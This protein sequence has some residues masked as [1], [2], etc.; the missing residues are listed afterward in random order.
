VRVWSGK[1]RLAY[2][3]VIGDGNRILTKWSEVAAFKGDLRVEGAGGK[4]LA[5]SVVGVHEDEDIAILLT[6]GSPLVPVKWSRE[7]PPL[8]SFL[9]TP[10]PDG[11]P[12]AFGVVSVLERN[13]RDTDQAYLGVIGD[14]RYSGTGVRIDDVAPDSGAAAAGLRKGNVI[15]RVGERSI[16]GLLE[17]RNSLVGIEP[18]SKVT[19]LIKDG[20]DERDVEVLLG[21]R[22]QLPNFPGDRLRQMEGM[23][24][25]QSRVRDSF[26]SVIQTDMRLRPNQ[27]GGPVVDLKGRV[28]GMTL[29][30][31]DRTRSFVIPAATVE[32]LLEGEAVDP[33]LA[34]VR[35]E[36]DQSPAMARN[37]AAR[38][39]PMKPRDVARLRRHHAEMQRLMEFMSEEM[40]AL[41]PQG[42]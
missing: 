26:T 18:G 5:A 40:N 30:R 38:Q 29:A 41:E 28:I 35:R 24:G 37:G 42:R 1:R 12:A 23:G 22:P 6:S 4:V 16:S 13:L 33:S 9:A 15:L 17:L 10:Q 11:R 34:E 25:P 14:A 21:N 8:G 36:Q 39:A 31:A 19:L 32:K 2:G 7:A 3:T 27:V 20:K